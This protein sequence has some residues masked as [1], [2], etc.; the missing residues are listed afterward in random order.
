[1]EEKKYAGFFNLVLFVSQVAILKKKF[2][3]WLYWLD[4]AGCIRDSFRY[5]K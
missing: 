3:F 4:N 5:E 2:F 1:M